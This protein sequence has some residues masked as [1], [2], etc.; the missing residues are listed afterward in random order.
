MGIAMEGFGADG[1]YRTEI[2]RRD[3]EK[4]GKMFTQPVIT[5]TT[6]PGGTDIDGMDG[7]KSYLLEEKRE[8]FARALVIKLMTYALGRSMELTDEDAIDQLTADFI[9]HDYQLHRL[10]QEVAACNAFL[11]K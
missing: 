2:P 3:P 10:V 11:T 5:E 1:L 9:E 6:L 4:K 8:Q 7:L